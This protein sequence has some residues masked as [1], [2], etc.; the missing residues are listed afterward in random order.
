MSK[1]K[2]FV[3]LQLL[4]FFF[5]NPVLEETFFSQGNKIQQVKVKYE[6]FGYGLLNYQ[7]KDLS[8]AF[9]ENKHISKRQNE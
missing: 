8:Q 6:Y 4:F 1:F 9:S 2:F 5:L 3:G 7:A